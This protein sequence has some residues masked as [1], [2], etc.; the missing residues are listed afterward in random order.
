MGV[1]PTSSK[2]PGT[3]VSLSMWAKMS[4]IEKPEAWTTATAPRKFS[5]LDLEKNDVTFWFNDK[6]VSNVSILGNI[7]VKWWTNT[8]LKLVKNIQDSKCVTLY[9]PG[10]RCAL[11]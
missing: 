8:N 7:V 6:H 5:A 3:L 9:K 1:L 4:S 11:E 10:L 2:R